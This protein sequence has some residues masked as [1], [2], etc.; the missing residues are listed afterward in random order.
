MVTVRYR[1]AMAGRKTLS[2]ED[3]AAAGLAAM[4]RGGPDAVAVEPVAAALGATK[5]SGYWHFAGRADLLATVLE[6]WVDRYTR[7]V[8]DRVEQDGGTP[9]DRLTHLLHIVSRGAEESPVEMLLAASADPAVRQA[10][11]TATELRVGYVERLVRASGVPRRE[12]RARAVLA[13]AAYLGYASITSTVPGLLPT[14]AAER[15]RMQETMLALA[16]APSS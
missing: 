7:Q 16:V 3:W 1:M 8:V 9:T 10:V 13:Y 2:R 14:R 11:V 5:G 12:A 15:R 4:M 6:A